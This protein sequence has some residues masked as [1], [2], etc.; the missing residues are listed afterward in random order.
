MPNSLELRRIGGTDLR[1]TRL[2]LGTV[3]LG[4]LYA[5]VGEEE[6]TATV[7]SALELGLRLFDAA[8]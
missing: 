5:P 7:E 3:A 4:F 2:G 8:P 1:V 6:A